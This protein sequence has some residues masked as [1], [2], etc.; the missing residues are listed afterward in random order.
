MTILAPPSPSCFSPLFPWLLCSALRVPFLF[1]LV[2]LSLLFV[3][4][5]FFLSLV[6]VRVLA[7][8][9]GSLSLPAISLFLVPFGCCAWS[10][11]PQ[12]RRHPHFL[13]SFHLLFPFPVLIA[14]LNISSS[15]APLAA[16]WSGVSLRWSLFPTFPPFL[17]KHCLWPQTGPGL[18]LL[19][20]DS[21]NS[22]LDSKQSRQV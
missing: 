3:W 8:V 22:L 11:W 2:L 12:T 4:V 17:T 9:V 14:L 18:L 7:R 21:W 19:N 5:C 6:S 20:T 16:D 10:F 13:L 1:L 15:V